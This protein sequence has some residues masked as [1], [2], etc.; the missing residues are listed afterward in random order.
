M[1]TTDE[2]IQS[3]LLYE[4][5]D[6]EL[7]LE[8]I[9]IL[10]KHKLDLEI[11][12]IDNIGDY[13]ITFEEHQGIVDL[14][15]AY[16]SKSVLQ[17]VP[18]YAKSDSKRLLQSLKGRAKPFRFMELPDP[19]KIDICRILLPDHVTFDPN[20]LVMSPKLPPILHTSQRLRRTLLPV[21]YKETTFGVHFYLPGYQWDK[22]RRGIAAKAAQIFRTWAYQMVPQPNIR[23]LRKVE[24]AGGLRVT[25][26]L[27]EK[28]GATG[29][30]SQS[31]ITY[32]TN[33]QLTAESQQL[34]KEHVAATEKYRKACG[35]EGEGLVLLLTTNPELWVKL[36]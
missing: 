24:L 7:W 13:D 17:R 34:L 12:D 28:K 21:F 11:E 1:P 23:W 10:L 22:Q 32:T 30:A 14:V 3:G 4:G 2:L 15:P 20:P 8:R 33:T 19:I 5:S 9:K 26:E 16:V 25:F 31:K 35:M 36:K 18:E 6:Y 27:S 29:A